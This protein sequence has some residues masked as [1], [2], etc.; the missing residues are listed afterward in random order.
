MVERTGTV[1]DVCVLLR[2]PVSGHVLLMERANTG[3][4]DGELGIPGGHLEAGESVVDGALREVAEEVGVDVKPDDLE[5][6]HVAHHRSAQGK[7]RIGFFFTARRWSGEPVNNEP[8]LCAGLRWVDPDALP[9]ATIPY[10]GDI[11]GL[12]Q[13]GE[14][15]SVHGW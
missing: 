12:I 11:I 14:H 15:F 13:V 3:F 4:G 10:I 5:C 6:A 9:A 1:V 7:T 8:D 2:D